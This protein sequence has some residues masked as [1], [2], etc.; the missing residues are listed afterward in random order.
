MIVFG[1]YIRSALILL[2]IDP[3]NIVEKIFK[4]SLRMSAIQYKFTDLLIKL[5]TIAP[6]ISRQE[7]SETSSWNQYF[8]LKKRNLQAF[9]C[10]MMLKALESVAP[11]TKVTVV[12][13]GDSAGT[14]MRYLKELK[15]DVLDIETISV[16]LDPAAI[17]KIKAT[18]QRAILCRA[19]DLD[20]GNQQ[21]DLFTSFQMVE[22]LHNPALFFRRLAVGSEC[23][24]MLIT[25][26][27]IRN[28]RVGLHSIRN[29]LRKSVHA[30]EEHIFELSPDDWTLLLLHSGWRVVFSQTYYQYPV[31]L[32]FIFRWVWKR[33]D[34]EGFW[35]AILEKDLTYTNLYQDWED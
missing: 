21:V 20:L 3:N 25:V 35:G 29:N 26:P 11:G 1:N 14:H 2:G 34:Y 23:K 8:E 22:H 18:G 10:V 6:D 17:E 12:D 4:C 24:R 32:F 31:W 16:N 7:L 15:K 13:I 19:E 27:Y 30:E 33:V 28:S 5:R 9:Q